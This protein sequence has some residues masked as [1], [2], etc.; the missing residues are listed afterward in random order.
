MVDW[1]PL[2]QWDGASHEGSGVFAPWADVQPVLDT[3]ILVDEVGDDEWGEWT[4]FVETHIDFAAAAA[5][6][7]LA[8]C[9]L[10]GWLTAVPALAATVCAVISVGLVAEIDRT[11][12]LAVVCSA[13]AT[14]Y[15]V[16]FAVSNSVAVEF[17]DPGCDQ[18]FVELLL[19]FELV[20]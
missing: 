8:V 20:R 4:A 16:A 19:S 9:K 11:F 6:D 5:V 18:P 3:A 10:S 17:I 13:F 1:G 7:A 14:R 2:E 12:L 15:R